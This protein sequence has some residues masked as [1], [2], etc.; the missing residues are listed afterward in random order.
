M[1][2]QQIDHAVRTGIITAGLAGFSIGILFGL[3]H[4]VQVGAALTDAIDIH[5]DSAAAGFEAS[6]LIIESAASIIPQ[7]LFEGA[8]L[9][10]GAGAIAGITSLC[11]YQLQRDLGDAGENPPPGPEK[12]FAT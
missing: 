8:A 3:T 11:S 2:W 9:E 7:F 5:G 1:A 4:S 6:S 10:A 12:G